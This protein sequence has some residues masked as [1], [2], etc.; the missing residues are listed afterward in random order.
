MQKYML[1]ISLLTTL[2]ACNGS[3]TI[4]PT[5]VEDIRIPIEATYEPVDYALNIPQGLPEME[6]PA[7]NPLT[8]AG[9]E[10]GRH[11][12]FDPI[13]S[14]DSTISCASCHLPELGF[15]DPNQFSLGVNGATGTRNAMS[16]VNVG[17]FTK[18]LF[19]DGSVQTLE[20]QA[21]MPVEDHREMN[22]A[23]PNVINKLQKHERYP[24]MF[25]E[26]FGIEYTD[27]IT[28][29]LAVKAIAQFE[30]T[31]ISGNSRYDQVLWG[32][33]VFLEDDE[34]NGRDL[35]FFELSQQ[36]D[37]PG[38][39]HCHNG[40]LLTDNRFVNNGLDSVA[41]LSAFT[42][43]GRGKVTG[44]FDNGKFRVPSLRNIALTAPY[45]HDGRFETLE[46]VIDHYVTGGHYADNIDA[47]MR[48]FTI[49]EQE[50]KDLI[51]F[52]KTFTD[53]EFVNNPNFKSPF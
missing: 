27:A 48:S 33:G 38:C 5:P 46:E 43:I 2:L 15:S 26:A 18:G 22:E 47:N 42:D 51:A 29:D 30:R 3:E 6:I 25:R 17:F 44:L 41:N 16:L 21:L 40:P 31:L 12:F 1:F 39:S 24:R 14:L 11:L 7:D 9:V 35:Y 4:D 37:H 36:N 19:W 52:L 45:M 53:E 10:L 28:K 8:V 49:T 34:L 20:E 13:L 50:K 32:D 23:W